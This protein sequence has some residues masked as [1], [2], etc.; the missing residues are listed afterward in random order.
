MD[1]R[2]S[3]SYDNLKI[4]HINNLPFF[5]QKR[6]YSTKVNRRNPNIVSYL[7]VLSNISDESSEEERYNFQY[8]IEK[9]WVNVFKQDMLNYDR[10]KDHV[11]YR[12]L[13]K[14]KKSLTIF[15][16]NNRYPKLYNTLPNLMYLINKIEYIIMAIVIVV[17]YHHFSSYTNICYKIGSVILF[18]IYF[19]INNIL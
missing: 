5:S 16:K 18:N 13:S 6:G 3:D 12:S 15:V 1:R 11:L 10:D 7:E 14:I 19:N 2:S 8:S 4:K 17:R 9:N